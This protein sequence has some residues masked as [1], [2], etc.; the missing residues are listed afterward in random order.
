MIEQC[1]ASVNGNKV[2]DV[3]AVVSDANLENQA[4]LLRAG[5]KK[6]HRVTVS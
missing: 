2:K 6:F 4:L 5:K 3:S 1:G